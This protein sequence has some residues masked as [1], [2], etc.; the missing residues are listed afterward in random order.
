M[1]DFIARVGYT[2]T[3]AFGYPKQT[4][5]ENYNGYLGVGIFILSIGCIST[6]LLCVLIPILIKNCKKD[7]SE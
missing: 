7:K 5:E 4:L 1:K 2:L 3:F 6:I